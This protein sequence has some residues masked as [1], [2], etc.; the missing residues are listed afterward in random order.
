MFGK[1]LQVS[2]CGN[3]VAIS[4]NDHSPGVLRTDRASTTDEALAE[5]GRGGTRYVERSPRSYYIAIDVRT[6]LAKDF[7]LFK[8]LLSAYE[9]MQGS[10]DPM[11]R[12][13]H[14]GT[15]NVA[16]KAWTTRLNNM[17]VHKD[18]DFTEQQKAIRI[19]ASA[20]FDIDLD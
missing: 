16:R 7:D 12:I 18:K 10:D 4:A 13:E 11:Y 19:A 17:K 6:A 5:A 2:N 8:P 3:F 14:Q 20:L 15:L 1:I 9:K